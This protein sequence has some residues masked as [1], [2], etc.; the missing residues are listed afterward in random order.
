MGANINPAKRWKKG[1]VSKVVGKTL[2]L[3]IRIRDLE[4]ALREAADDV[5]H[6]GPAVSPGHVCGLPDSC[7]DVDCMEAADVSER[8][9]RYRRIAK[10]V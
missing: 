9:A 5:S 8:V 3:S 7:C 4:D 1:V 10:G 2:Y 6:Y